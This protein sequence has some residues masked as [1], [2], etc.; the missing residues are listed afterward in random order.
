MENII[1]ENKR[2]KLDRP[3]TGNISEDRIWEQW[4]DEDV[5][6]QKLP[7]MNQRDYMFKCNDDFQNQI[8]INNRGKS[9][10]SVA[11]FKGMV[12]SFTNSFV[13][14]EMSM[15]DIICTI[16]LST[17]ELLSVK[18]SCST[19]GLIT[20]NLNF[21]DASIKSG[22]L[23]KMYNQLK[24]INPRMIFFLDILENQIS[25]VLNLPEFK[26]IKKVRMPLNFSNNN[27]DLE[28]LKIKFLKFY[29]DISKKYVQNSISLTD[30]L[31]Q[32]QKINRIVD[33]VY[34][35]GLPSNIAFTSGTTGQNKAVL[36]SHDANN[37]L[38]FQHKMANLGLERGAKHLA[39]VPPFLAFWDADIIHMAMCMGVEN[40]LELSLTYENIPKYMEKY[41][42]Q[43]GIWSQ[44]LWDSILHLPP[45]KLKVISSN[46]KKAVVGGERCEINQAIS[47]YEKTGIIQEAGF[48][49]T[50]VN[51]CFSVA[52]PN[53]NVVGSAG[54]PLPFNNV[55]IVGDNF[56]EL[57]YNQ[58]GRLLITGPC[59]MNGYYGRQDLTNDVFIKDKKG[60]T[61]YD[62]KDYAIIDKNGNLYVLDRDS[63]P[64]TIKNN[65]VTEKVKLLDLAEKIKINRAIKICKLTS[66]D[67]YIVLHVVI[68]EFNE[69]SKNES[70][71][72]II[73]TIKSDLE[74]KY[75]PNV[76]NIMDS[77]PRT[78]VGK[79]DYNQ[80][81]EI[82]KSI[83]LNKGLLS[84]D[85]LEV[86]DT[87]I[88]RN[89][90]VKK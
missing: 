19:L 14:Y 24:T 62:T 43:Y 27:I 11:E 54:I 63:K 17:P 50:E 4:Y 47:F 77:L 33:S 70:I 80:L 78:Q 58:C 37:A 57:S 79:V 1:N 31:H 32:G 25:N 49:A 7:K 66:F 20:S 60:V 68:D 88:K 48:G 65:G 46:L 67:G 64:I 26:H 35:E 55:K 83:Y 16:G 53:C 18:Y 76:I 71:D 34:K 41:L 40:I 51:T 45:D 10:I 3:I 74:Q 73:N 42:P 87:E 82:T 69:M 12:D 38:A 9:R 89:Q 84:C 13:A 2:R 56:K 21:L 86:I 85:K 75:W 52:N 44:Y 72:S 22:N 29:N 36:L 15:G 61:W 6:K 30:F 5:F 90:K 59:L 81:D 8:I 28:N 39:L 23:N